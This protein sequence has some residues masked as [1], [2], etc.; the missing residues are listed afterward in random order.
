MFGLIFISLEFG[1]RN[2]YDSLSKES[3]SFVTMSL[4]S[5]M[6]IILQ[7]FK[8]AG[9]HLGRCPDKH[10]GVCFSSSIKC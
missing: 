5:E 2:T 4:K 7:F 3:F 10:L 9:E 1:L 6:L 8:I